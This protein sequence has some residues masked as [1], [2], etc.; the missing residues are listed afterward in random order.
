MAKY[1][2]GQ[3]MM[4]DGEPRE[5]GEEVLESELLSWPGYESYLRTRHVIEVADDYFEDE[6]ETVVE[7]DIEEPVTVPPQVIKRKQ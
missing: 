1:M 3:R 6:L 2:A 5:Y 4:I 7:E